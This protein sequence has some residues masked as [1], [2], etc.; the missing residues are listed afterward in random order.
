MI[1]VKSQVGKI[2]RRSRAGKAHPHIGPGP[3]LVG[4]IEGQHIGLQDKAL[5]GF[6]MESLAV[7]LVLAGSLQDI[8][9]HVVWPDS[10]SRAVK[11]LTFGVAA[12]AQIEILY[13]PV[14]KL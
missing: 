5:A 14:G 4:L 10:R 11:R 3:R 9:D 6:Q 1:V 13:L 8:V 12:E 2:F 7:Y